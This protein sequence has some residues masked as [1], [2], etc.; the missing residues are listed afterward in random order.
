MK[1]KIISLTIIGCVLGIISCQQPSNKI[2]SDETSKNMVIT[3][4]ILKAFDE[5]NVDA[6]DSFIVANPIDHSMP[7]DIKTSGI[8]AVKEMSKAQKAAFPDIKT[9]INTMMAEGDMVMVYFT[10]EGTNSGPFMG[11]PATGKKIKTEGVDIIKFKDGKAVE[12]WGVYDNLKMMQQLGLLPE[13]SAVH[14][15]TKMKK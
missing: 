7:P 5:G 6:L 15:T 1:T 9:T 11:K 13:P 12:H 4:K 2:A 14:D 3:E 8:E 10:S